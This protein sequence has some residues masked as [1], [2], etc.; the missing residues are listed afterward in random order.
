MFSSRRMPALRALDPV[1][2]GRGRERRTG[3]IDQISWMTS[4]VRNW[5]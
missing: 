4:I 2:L 1:V 5:V 3:S